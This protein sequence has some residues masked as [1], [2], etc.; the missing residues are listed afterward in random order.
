MPKLVSLASSPFTLQ[1]YESY[2]RKLGWKIESNDL[3]PHTYFGAWTTEP[4]FFFR[5]TTNDDETSAGLAVCAVGADSED[6]SFYVENKRLL[7]KAFTQALECSRNVLGEPLEAGEY[8]CESVSEAYHFAYWGFSDANLILVEHNETE[9]SNDPALELRL[10]P[11]IDC[12]PLKF[13]LQTKLLL[14]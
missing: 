10:F 8:Y 14:C 11:V 9:F 4:K 6:P 2:C 1:S 7:S 5:L 3:A 13:P 12:K